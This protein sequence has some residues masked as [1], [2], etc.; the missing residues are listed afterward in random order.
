MEGKVECDEDLAI[1]IRTILVRYAKAF[2]N[3]WMGK[4]RCLH[5]IK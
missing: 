3:A 1:V 5:L 4:T 2:K